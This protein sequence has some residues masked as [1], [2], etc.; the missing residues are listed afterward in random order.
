MLVPLAILPRTARFLA[1]LVALGATVQHSAG[2]LASAWS[3][4]ERLMALAWVAGHLVLSVL[5]V[6]LGVI[7][8]DRCYPK[9]RLDQLSDN[10]AAS[11]QRASHILAAGAVSASLWGGVD[12]H[13]CLVAV[14]FQ[15]LGLATLIIASSVHRSLT[16]YCDHEQIA[17]GNLAVGISSAGLHLAIAIVVS[18]AMQGA[19]LGWAPSLIAY[20]YALCWLFLFWPLRQLLLARYI[21]GQPASTM[22]AAI[23]ID[24]R[25]DIAGA[26]ALSYLVIALGATSWL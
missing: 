18:R 11:L 7:V 5:S 19:F 2:G 26:E 15:V 6:F 3:G 25:M 9:I 17:A 20:G 16:S 14:T 23:A 13:S 22:D 8:L 24:R 1:V 12:A 21:L 10:D 4:P